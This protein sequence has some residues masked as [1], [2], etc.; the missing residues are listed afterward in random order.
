MDHPTRRDV[1]K[2]AG[3]AG[4]TALL[5]DVA[6]A[7]PAPAAAVIAHRST[8]GV[9]IPPRGDSFMSFSFDT[10]EP[11]VRFAGLDVGFTIF[12][13]ENTY[14]LDER[15]LTVEATPDG[16]RLICD[17]VVW[18]GGQETAPG[19]LEA[20]LRRAGAWI[21][22][23]ATA[24]LPGP[25]K[26]VTTIVR[27][28]PRGKVGAGGAA[29]VDVHDDEL[30]FGYPFGGGDL[31]GGN[32]ARGISTPFLAIDDGA[33]VHFVASLDDRVR[34]KRFYLQ[35]GD[36]GY[37]LEAIHE[38]EGWLP[39][40]R[41][42]V[43]PWRIGRAASLD[44][45]LAPHVQHLERAYHIPRWDTRPDVP[46][47]LRRTALVVAMH[48]MHFSGYVFNTFRRMLDILRWMAPQLP[49]D[50]V[51]VFLP[52][53]D[54][55]YYWDYPEYQAAARLGGETELRRLI[56]EGKRLGFRFMPMFGANTANRRL[57]SFAQL[58]DAATS[59]IDDDRMDLDWVDWDNDRHQEGWAAYMNLGVES[60]RRWLT[61]RIA[62]AI[63]RYGIDGYFLDIVGGWVNNT[64]ADMHEGV[65]QLVGDLRKRY[66]HVLACGEFHYDAL[67]ELIPLYQVHSA[68][69][70]PFARFFSHL[71]HP[72]PGRGSSGV[73]ESGFSR[74]DPKTLSLPRREGLIPTLTVVDDTFTTHRSEMAAVIRE[75]RLRA[76][77]G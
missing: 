35:P 32:R 67:L 64:R 16:V 19:R 11:S 38:A 60:W 22:I 17:G 74:F 47:W 43:P 33:Q 34:T 24:E 5:S 48:G 36:H 30:L 28:L 63:D 54:G 9:F 77:L 52:A 58:A 4:T 59:K 2:A 76:G 15:K 26:A 45:A 70:V 7:A 49:P 10:P 44:A 21:E 65:R 72:A 50:R 27:G 61:G 51:L 6:S 75:A 3:V 37:R 40:T 42:S 31:F 23:D 71:S 56:A 39:R 25:I 20:N 29:P 69:A 13:R 41:I 53:W 68:H 8:T 55:R 62:A 66:P 18:A 1:L 12:S 14:H 57:P 46:A 73:H